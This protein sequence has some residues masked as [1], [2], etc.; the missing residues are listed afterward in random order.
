M[1]KF[2]IA[3]ING[4]DL[5]ADVHVRLSGGAGGLPLPDGGGPIPIRD[6]QDVVID[7]LHPGADLH[8]ESVQEAFDFQ[9]LPIAV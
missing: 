9:S 1:K 2:E 8:G 7:L 4:K 6:P 5:Q 3:V